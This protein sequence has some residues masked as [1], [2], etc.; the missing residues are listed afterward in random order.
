MTSPDAFEETVHVLLVYSLTEGHLLEQRLFDS[1]SH[2][3]PNNRS[4]AATDAYFEV[5][6]RHRDDT[7]VEIV[8]L[9]SDSLESVQATHGSYFVGAI[10]RPSFVTDLSE[11]FEVFLSAF[12]RIAADREAPPNPS[13]T[14]DEH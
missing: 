3:D 1:D 8:L 5:E 4:R 2:P 12:A 13:R 6:K 7:D 14:S 9:A 10:R 11:A